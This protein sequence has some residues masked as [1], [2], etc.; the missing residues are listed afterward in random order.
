MAKQKIPQT[1]QNKFSR[2]QYKVGDYV[3]IKFLGEKYYGYVKRITERSN[4]FVYM[5]QT[6]GYSYPCGIQIKDFF[7]GTAGNILFDD[8]AG[9]GGEE[10]KRQFDAGKLPQHPGGTATISRSESTS[11]R[12]NDGETIRKVSSNRTKANKRR[13]N[14]VQPSDTTVSETKPTRRK[15]YSAL[16]QAIERQKD[17]LRKFT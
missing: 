17:F 11:S 15:S 13:T 5:V 1:I 12:S 8:T 7:S 4:T 6:N 3:C 10:I 14:D 9:L 16:D 2:Q